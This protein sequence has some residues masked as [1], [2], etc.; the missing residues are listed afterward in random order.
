MKTIQ[1]NFFIYLAF[2]LVSI[3]LTVFLGY[4]DEGNSQN[5]HSFFNYILTDAFS[6]I[7][8]DPGCLGWT[9]L[10][11]ISISLTFFLTK[12]IPVVKDQTITRIA[13][14]LPVFPVTLC[15][16]F[17]LIGGVFMFFTKIG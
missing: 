1:I 7:V 9:I 10:F 3:F 6:D 13:F 2:L 12:F 8:N 11:F 14:T 16:V 4:I 15:L 5:Y 17:L